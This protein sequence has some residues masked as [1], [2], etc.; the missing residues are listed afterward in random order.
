MI[1]ADGWSSAIKVQNCSY[2]SFSGIYSR[3]VDNPYVSGAVGFNI[4]LLN[5]HHITLRR[6]LAYGVNRY[7]N[8]STILLEHTDDS[9][10]EEC[11]AYFFHRKGISLGSASRNVIR[12]NYVH[13]RAAADLCTGCEGDTSGQS[14]RK[15]DEGINLA[16]PGSDNIAENN[17]SEG[18]YIG[19][20]LSAKG[21]STRNRFYGNIAI[22]NGLG[23]LVTS[24]GAGPTRTPQQ[25]VLTNN[26]AI[27]STIVGVYLRGAEETRISNMTVIDT[28]A[29][30]SGHGIAADRSHLNY[31][32]QASQCNAQTAP[33]GNG[34]ASTYIVNS[35]SVNNAG[36]GF[37]INPALQEGGWSVKHSNAHSN[38]WN[39]WPT[40]IDLTDSAINPHLGACKVWIPDG[41]PMK[42][43][44]DDGDDIGAN[45]LYQYENGTATT[46]RLWDE[47]GRFPHG[48]LVAGVNDVPGE[49][50]FDVHDRLNVN[51]NGCSFPA[52]YAHKP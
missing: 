42:G 41:S 4:A 44:A 27:A 37:G 39:F 31:I 10:I 40:S 14:S 52:G 49:S 22:N 34:G 21:A 1:L 50:A 2:W 3:Q 9:L 12:R 26:A 16:Y 32:T 28:Q 20:S 48:A 51:A 15:G 45:I 6:C 5:S 19:F 30:S 46:Q 38:T 33:C 29:G 17:I 13:S 47:A 24:R 25:T 7:L 43:A 18:S 35:L 11:E 36:A 8:V 23:Y